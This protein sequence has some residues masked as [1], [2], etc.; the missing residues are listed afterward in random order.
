MK[1]I[2]P[3]RRANESRRHWIAV[4][5]TSLPVLAKILIVDKQ[6]VL[7]AIGRRR[8]EEDLRHGRIVRPVPVGQSEVTVSCQ[9]PDEAFVSQDVGPVPGQE[10][11]IAM[12]AEVIG[13]EIQSMNTGEAHPA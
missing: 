8:L 12:R 10:I 13:A 9:F 5:P 11:P 1:N 2:L 6:P 4:R 3:N 7:F